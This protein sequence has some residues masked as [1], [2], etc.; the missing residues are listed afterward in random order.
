MLDRKKRRAK[1]HTH[2][3]EKK[4]A[5]PRAHSTTKNTT[6]ATTGTTIT[7]NNTSSFPAPGHNKAPPFGVRFLQEI[8][9]LFRQDYKTEK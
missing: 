4:V 1:K 9:N 7:P 8:L 2:T 6:A 3:H 5:T